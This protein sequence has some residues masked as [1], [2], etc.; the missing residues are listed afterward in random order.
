MCTVL[1]TYNPKNR[2]AHNL[3]YALSKTRG[4]K[5][6]DE[7]VLTDDEII[8]IEESRRSGI[9]YDIDKLKEKLRS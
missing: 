8:R 1:V 7:A 5:I 9:L 2:A 6:D 3:M 4:V